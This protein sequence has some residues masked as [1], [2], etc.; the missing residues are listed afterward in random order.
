MGL[1]RTIAADISPRPVH[2]AGRWQF[3]YPV[4]APFIHRLERSVVAALGE[5][6]G[7]PVTMPESTHEIVSDLGKPIVLGSPVQCDYRGGIISGSGA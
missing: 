1:R 4:L 3:R 2:R 5:V 7:A 6:S